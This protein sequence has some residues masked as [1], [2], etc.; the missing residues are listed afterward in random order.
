[1]SA[2]EEG[3]AERSW[4]LRITEY[5]RARLAEE[6]RRAERYGRNFALLYVSCRQAD[7]RDVFNT[8]R[9]YLRCTDLVEV[10]SGRPSAHTGAEDV[11]EVLRD[12]V[13]V[14]L[15]ETDRGRARATLE[16]L[17]ANLPGLEDFEIGLAVF[18]DDGTN[19]LEL[20]AQAAKRAGEEFHV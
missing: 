8:L 19:P 5:F 14:I 1:M 2:A 7:A 13:A 9:P 4:G 15:P 12:R 20:L 3:Q 16:R 18:P 11:E 10:I 6:A 17:R